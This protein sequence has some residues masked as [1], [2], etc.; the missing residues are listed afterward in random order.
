VSGDPATNRVV[1]TIDDVGSGVGIASDGETIYVRTRYQG[2]SRID[3]A[4]NTASPVA[5]LVEWNYGLAYGNGELWVTS[6]DQERA[7]RMEAASLG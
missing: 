3:P 4:T 7:Y 6:V 2:I 1:A 5:Q